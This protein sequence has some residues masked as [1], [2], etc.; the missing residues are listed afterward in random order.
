MFAGPIVT[1]ARERAEVA[2]PPFPL[3]AEKR[4]AAGTQRRRHRS[5]IS[6]SVKEEGI[7]S[8]ASAPA[9]HQI[10]TKNATTATR[11]TNAAAPARR[12]RRAPRPARLAWNELDG[13]VLIGCRLNCRARPAADVHIRTRTRSSS[14]RPSS[15]SEAT[16]PGTPHEL[17]ISQNF[18]TRCILQPTVCVSLAPRPPG[19]F[20]SAAGAVSKAP[21][22]DTRHGPRPHYFPLNSLGGGLG[23]YF[24]R[25]G[26]CVLCHNYS[27]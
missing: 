1:T 3:R 10:N 15:L 23:T 27:G 5:G 9:Q 22:P 4:A 25:P 6:V 14:R 12:G 19:G 26:G 7:G 16:S 8:V 17:R 18:T 2:Q 24:I 21:R 13:V 11:S 20:A